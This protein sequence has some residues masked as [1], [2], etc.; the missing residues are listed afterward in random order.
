MVVDLNYCSIVYYE[1]FSKPKIPPLREMD[2]RCNGSFHWSYYWYSLHR[3]LSYK[4]SQYRFVLQTSHC[5]TSPFSMQVYTS[6]VC[7]ICSLTNPKNGGLAHERSDVSHR[8]C[9]LSRDLQPLWCSY[10][11]GR[12]MKI[13]AHFQANNA[14]TAT[15]FR[16]RYMMVL[17]FFKYVWLY[18]DRHIFS[19][20]MN[21]IL[22]LRVDP[23]LRCG[24]S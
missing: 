17:V 22:W 10:R 14:T 15:L 2:S 16:D 4:Y 9:F 20:D 24:C 7:V 11:L 23:Y 6:C 8:T 3:L 1:G 5:H 21:F 18:H 19:I 12:V 13:A